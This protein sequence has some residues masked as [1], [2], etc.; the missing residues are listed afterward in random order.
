MFFDKFPL[1]RYDISKDGNR[2]LAVDILKR[3]VFR[4]EVRNQGKLFRNYTIKDGE[5]PEQVAYSLY[6]ECELHWILLLMNEIID[7]YF[8]WPMSE[9]QLND[10]VTKK[11]PGQAIYLGNSEG[12]HF[13]K[14]EEVFVSDYKGTGVAYKDRRALVDSYDPTT[15]KLTLYAQSGESDIHVQDTIEGKSSGTTGDVTRAVRVNGESLH[16]FE[17]ANT[18]YLYTKVDPLATPPISG[19]QVPIGATGSSWESG[20]QGVTFG[21]TI[22][23]SYVNRLDSSVTTHSV[24]TNREYERRLNES[25][26]NIKVLLQSYVSTVVEDFARVINS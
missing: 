5:T 11:Y 18:D 16:H 19:I 9:S 14:N 24:V 6:G 21:D 25:R 15:R 26:R 3:V 20:T 7:P 23:H 12:L 17:D 10:Y 2:K 4:N 8:E 22:L 1:L 13:T